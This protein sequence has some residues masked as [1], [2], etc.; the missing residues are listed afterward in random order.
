[1]TKTL[2]AAASIIFLVS[3]SVS[4]QDTS[5][6]RLYGGTSFDFLYHVEATADGAFIAVGGTESFGN[7][8]SDVWL[9]KFDDAGDTLWTRTFGGPGQD[10]GTC[11]QQTLDGGYV[12]T[13]YLN[14]DGTNLTGYILKTDTLGN[15]EWEQTYDSDGAGGGGIAPRYVRQIAGGG[16]M[17][18]GYTWD[19]LSGLKDGFLV[20]LDDTG[21]VDSSHLPYPSYIAEWPDIRA[22]CFQPTPDGGY[23]AAGWLEDYGANW[24]GDVWLAKTDSNLVTQWTRFY[25]DTAQEGCWHIDPTASG[26]YIL[27]GFKGSLSE[28]KEDVYLML[29]DAS[30]DSIW[31]KTY[32]GNQNDESRWVRQTQDGGFLVAGTVEGFEFGY[33]ADGWLLKTDSD[34]DTVWTYRLGSDESDN[35]TCTHETNSGEYVVVGGTGMNWDPNTND[36]WILKITSI[37]CCNHDGV[38]GDVNQDLQG[39]NIVDLTYLVAYLFSAGAEPPCFQ[40][41]DVN[42]DESVNIVDLTYLAAYL[43]GGGSP[44]QP[45]P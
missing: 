26:G 42:A 35:F 12:V 10:Y 32:G 3:L 23:L 9:L 44:P 16:Y 36:G 41:G 8:Q 22:Y 5:W 11:V 19:N 28:G 4:A 37:Q 14:H 40:E 27:A 29:T 31:T 25:G 20:R 39:P 33:A 45:C 2:L 43:F 17:I 30:G 6:T 15:L 38:R 21:A 7:G 13:G 1:M 24:G 18:C 34:G